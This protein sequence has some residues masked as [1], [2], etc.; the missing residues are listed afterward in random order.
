MLRRNCSTA[1][2]LGQCTL[3]YLLILVQ[4]NALNLH[5]RS[6]HHIRRL[7]F[8]DEVV[9]RLDIHRSITHN[10][11]RNKLA[12]TL[13]VECLYGD[14]LDARKLLDDTF[15]LAHLNTE[16]ANLHLS[17]TTTN[18]LQIAIGQPANNVASMIDAVVW[19]ILTE[20]VRREG[21]GILLRSV[22]IAAS[23]LWTANP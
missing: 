3:V 13:V 17:V 6:R 14:I 12:A 15:H 23:H 1:D 7:S 4:R 18:K 16:T 8:E 21:L 10:I 19:F 9:Q 11:S 2:W 5:R 22:Q 20:R